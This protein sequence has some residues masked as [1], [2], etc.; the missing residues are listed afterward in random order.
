MSAVAV[1]NRRVVRRNRRKFRRTP[2]T[3]GKRSP[4]IPPGIYEGE[5]NRDVV[6]RI[7]GLCQSRG[8]ECVDLVPEQTNVSLKTR[9]KRAKDFQK[10]KGNCIYLSIHANAAGSGDWNSAKGITTFSQKHQDD[11]K[12]ASDKLAKT[13]QNRLVKITGRK[14]RGVRNAGFYVLRNTDMPR[15]L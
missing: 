14:D 3:K 15:G 10:K 7:A 6:K 12:K 4:Q 9:V 13:L 2:I 11:H 5:F 8:I 1:V